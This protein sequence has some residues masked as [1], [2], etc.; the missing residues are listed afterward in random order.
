MER[1]VWQERSCQLNSFGYC[2]YGCNFNALFPHGSNSN[3]SLYP[4]KI[5]EIKHS[6][7]DSTLENTKTH[8]LGRA[9]FIRQIV[10]FFVTSGYF[11]ASNTNS[12]FIGVSLFFFTEK[13]GKIPLIP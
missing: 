6:V 2:C 1:S 8:T 10:K 12:T 7:G 5:F 3:D 13:K 9:N 11:K 4:H